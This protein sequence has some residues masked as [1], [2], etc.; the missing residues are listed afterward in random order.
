ME[1]VKPKQKHKKKNNHYNMG[2]MY[3]LTITTTTEQKHFNNTI[4]II[5][6]TMF[7]NILRILL[8]MRFMVWRHG[9]DPWLIN[10]PCN[11]RHPDQPKPPTPHFPIPIYV[12]F[13]G[14][15]PQ[16]F[17]LL[18]VF[19][20]VFT[21]RFCLCFTLSI[22]V[23]VFVR[24]PPLE[25]PPPP[26]SALPISAWINSVF[27]SANRRRSWS[28]VLQSFRVEQQQRQEQVN[29]CGWPTTHT[30]PIRHPL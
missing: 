14:F 5:I 2:I 1:N 17:S 29:P 22:F 19:I 28:F 25:T 21:C 18:C 6:I 27:K 23:L 30:P 12:H 15:P 10:P 9:C 3:S 4:T 20:C 13:C 8:F 7:M 24:L 26:H 16:Y 11:T